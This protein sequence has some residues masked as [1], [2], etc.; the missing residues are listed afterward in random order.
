MALDKLIKKIQRFPGVW[1]IRNIIS[2]KEI[3]ITAF[4]FQIVHAG[5]KGN[6]ITVY[7]RDYSD[8]HA[9]ISL[10]FLPELIL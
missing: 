4:F 6:N 5:A 7:V 2:Q 9:E 3:F 10:L 8:F 1:R